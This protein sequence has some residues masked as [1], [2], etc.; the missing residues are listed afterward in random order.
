[1]RPKPCL[2]LVTAV[3]LVFAPLLSASAQ[4]SDPVPSQPANS[5]P[6]LTPTGAV[7]A[8]ARQTAPAQPSQTNGQQPTAAKTG[9]T[10]AAPLKT[11]TRLIAVD[12][13]ATDSHGKVIR[14]LKAEDFQ[15]MEER[16]GQQKIS[17][18]QFIDESGHP[19]PVYPP[20]LT[21]ALAGAPFMF[22]NLLPERMSVPPTV[23]LM[24]ALNTELQNQ[25]E[26]HRHMLALLKTLPPSTPIA[27]FVLGHQL[28][29][30]QSFTTDPALLRAALDHTLRAPDIAANPQDDADSPSNQFLDQN[31]ETETTANQALEDFEK[32]DYEAQMSLRVDETTDAM[33]A[34]SKF[35]GGYPG[36]KNLLWFSASFPNWIAPNAD[37]GQDAFMGSADYTDKIRKATE[38]L[39]DARIA[40]YPVDARGLETNSIYSTASTPHINRNNPG[41]SLA[42]TM[43]RD[44]STRIDTQ[45][46]MQM[47][48]D[49]SG[50]K[51]CINTNDLSGCVQTALDDSSAYYEL[52]YYPE[53]VKW[54]AR[55]HRITVKTTEKGVKLRY[56]TGYFATEPGASAKLTPVDLLK[57]ACQDPLASTAI[58]MTAETLAPPRGLADPNGRYLLT[59]SP[60]PLTFSPAAQARQLNLQMA[61]CDF[62]ANGS[63]FQF[64]PRD[65]S[66][67][68]TDA[69]YQA[70]QTTG[71]RNI[72]DF[73][74]RPDDKKLRFA[75]LDVPSGAIGSID[76]PA[77]PKEY[78]LVPA[79]PAAPASSAS[80]SPAAA[81]P[82]HVGFKGSNGSTSMLDWAGDAVSYHGELTVDQGARALYASLFGG[83]YHCEDSS[84]VPNDISAPGKPSLSLTLR[85]ADGRKAII[86]LSGGSPAYSGDVPVDSAGRSFFDY[87]WKLCHCQQP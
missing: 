42:G 78:G 27:V 87:L 22:T 26:V 30:L 13:I 38:A 67:S 3:A 5:Q 44:N 31:N 61:V 34:I 1:M 17:Q 33:V 14:G 53:N 86:D 18:F 21:S 29:V 75:V 51:V 24:D 79:A 82:T 15:I 2:T 49:S 59:I 77:H 20:G 65:L 41:G 16:G 58:P 23:M 80:S 25:S 72:F 12:V 62:D 50:G 45:A 7:K 9:E 64:F 37:F 84:L 60:V 55:F 46:T 28:H 54:D 10:T 32:M 36:R 69:Q 70:W 48:A 52:G 43:N 68:I 47:I 83:K 73:Q 39:T 63:S 8:S 66:A 85:K 56:R 11:N 19:A 76:V 4:S 81:P 6:R 40:V 35:L 71:V 74:A 57:Q